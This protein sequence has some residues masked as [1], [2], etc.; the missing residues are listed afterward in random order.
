MSDTNASAARRAIPAIILFVGA[1]L[2]AGIIGRLLGGQMP[3]D[4]YN[5]LQKPAFNPP[6]W[7]F[8]PVWAFLYLTMGIAAWLV[9]LKHGFRCGAAP[10]GLFA[11]QLLLNAIW[12]GLF[13]GMEN[14]L[15][16]FF[17]IVALWLALLA[18]TVAFFRASAPAG[19]LMVPYL[20]WVSFAAVLNFELW[21]LNA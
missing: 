11:G 17:D 16:A 2:L 10:L 9:W 15:L 6:G 1:S 4:W 5:A 18:T 7:V 13:F 21:R 8:G 19:W 14:P 20:L 3:D 12:S